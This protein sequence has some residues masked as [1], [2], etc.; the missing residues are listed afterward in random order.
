MKTVAQLNVKRPTDRLGPD[1][2]SN[3]AEMLITMSCVN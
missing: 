1:M 2:A 3:I